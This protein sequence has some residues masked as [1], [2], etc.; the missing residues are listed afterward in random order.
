ML[1]EGVCT[2]SYVNATGFEAANHMLAEGDCTASCM[3]CRERNLAVLH[4]HLS[5]EQQKRATSH[6]LHQQQLF[7]LENQ[8]KVVLN[9][10]PRRGLSLHRQRSSSR[11]LDKSTSGVD[12][13]NRTFLLAA[14]DIE[15]LTT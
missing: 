9:P 15:T 6:F 7:L 12:P 11:P 14:K 13:P 8:T 10:P 4:A 3:R 5:L 2:A 1:A